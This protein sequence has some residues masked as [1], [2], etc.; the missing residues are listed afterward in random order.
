MS[1]RKT[2]SSAKK[3][4]AKAASKRKASAGSSLKGQLI[5]VES[6]TKIKT[7]KKFLGQGYAVLATKGHI[8]DLPKSKL[9]VDLAN[10]FQPHYTTI[11]G[12][13]QIIKDL[14][15]EASG[16]ARVF[17]AP[18]P[19]REGEA[20]AHHLSLKLAAIAGEI[21]RVTFNEI[22]KNAVLK[23]L[24]EA[25]DLDMRKVY[26]QQARRI[27]DR[28]VGYQVSPILWQTVYSG[29]S[30]G[31]VQSVA[32]R[33]ICEREREILSFEPREYWSVDADFEASDQRFPAKLVRID[34]KDVEISNQE[35]AEATVAD[36][37]THSYR[38][39][40]VTKDERK[41]YPLPPYITSTLQQD[42][43]RQV[44]FSAQKT[45]IIAQ[46]LYEGVELGGQGSVG[47][48]TYMRTDSIRSADEA[49][50]AARAFVGSKYGSRYLPES[51]R[52]F[53]PKK[54][55]Q[56]AHEAIRPTNLE[57]EPSLIRQYLSSDQYK[58][59]NLIFGRFV[60]SQ[61]EPAVYDQ[62]R[63]DITGDRY[64]FRAVDTKLK[65]DG[66]LKVYEEASDDDNGGKNGTTPLP[67]L[68]A[69][70]QVR[71]IE[72][73]PDQHFTKPPPRYSEASLVKELEANGIGRPS[74]YAQIINT[75]K[76]RK[77]VEID[78]RRLTPTEL[79][80]TVSRI[81]VEHFER[82]F[83]IKFTAVMEDE[84]DRIEEGEDDWVKVLNDFYL[85]FSENLKEVEGKIVNIRQSAQE[86]SNEL[87][88]KCGAA[89]VVKWGR[90]GK[91]L[92]CSAY[93]DCRNTRPLDNSDNGE[94]V[95]RDCPKCGEPLVYRRGRFGKFIACSS[96]PDCKYTESITTG[97]KCPMK[98]CDGELAQRRSAR[99][100]IFYGCTKYPECKFASWYKPVA[101]E[102]TACGHPLMVEK[103]TRKL[104]RH[105]ACP[106][107]KHVERLSEEEPVSAEHNA[108]S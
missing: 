46:Q 22:T 15:K 70:Q 71:L 78:R 87:C 60:A 107:C 18:D 91:F 101:R 72:V 25:A 27:L 85:P 7:L 108:G 106:E 97:V 48:I 12:K 75:L 92:A 68:S 47:L 67:D 69:D 96:Y 39:S 80:T 61:M 100:K 77:Y 94:P 102:C 3:P 4:M 52:I 36:I 40:E 104:G 10:G 21:K 5:I 81:L 56:D 90:N 8:L 98:E 74:T 31:R 51:P 30:A 42:A 82:I 45:M 13:A 26:A 105:L 35:A 1:P 95:E 29:L 50:A 93:P 57:N 65:F 63:V 73:T 11:H 33:M 83:D 23:G 24:E 66:Y 28:L 53:K 88:D 64:L 62:V 38:V 86:E 76:Q 44:G 19:D 32:L 43:A 79:G 34:G 2:T 16:K 20:I 41:R 9:G 49:I 55:S 6:P 84:L 37:K 103:E 59:Y 99:G 14:V 17:L 58:L 54:R 89:M